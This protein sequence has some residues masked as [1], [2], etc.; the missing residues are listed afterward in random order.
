MT[1]KR[2]VAKRDANGRFL[3]GNSGNPAGRPKKDREIR[4]LEITLSTVRY[5]DWRKIVKKAVTQA[6]RGDNQARKFLADY[7]LGPPAQRLE[8]S[9][10]EGGEVVIRVVGGITP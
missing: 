10:P 8:H 7:L 9:G 2:Q 1:R 3:P 4:F 6:Q 5:E